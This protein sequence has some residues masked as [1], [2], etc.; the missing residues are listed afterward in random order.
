MHLG[1]LGVVVLL[2]R[3]RAGVLWCLIAVVLIL[4]SL[5]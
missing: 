2:G 3:Y 1:C 5:H 4:K